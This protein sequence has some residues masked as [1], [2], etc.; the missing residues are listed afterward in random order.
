MNLQIFLRI[1]NIKHLK[2]QGIAQRTIYNA[3]NRLTNEQTIYDK[4]RT[5]QPSTWD[6]K[7]LAKP[8]PTKRPL[9]RH[10]I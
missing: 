1:L 6:G 8:I 9:T 7:K 2:K 10:F 5:S 4:K 3:I